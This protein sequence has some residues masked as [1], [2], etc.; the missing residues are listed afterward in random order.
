VV[1]Y[2]TQAAAVRIRSGE[3]GSTHTDVTSLWESISAMPEQPEL[4]V[5]PTDEDDGTAVSQQK[6]REDLG[7]S[8]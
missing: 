6:L 3:L 4:V 2:Y 7:D 1:P 8:F 5:F